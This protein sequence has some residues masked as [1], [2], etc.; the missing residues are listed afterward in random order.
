MSN[1]N[2]L[3]V[4]ANRIGQFFESMPDRP[5]ALEGIANHIRKFW[6]PRMRAEFLRILDAAEGAEISPIVREAVQAH[7][8]LLGEA[9]SAAR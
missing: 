7:R 4:M 2:N 3:I 9:L 6:E 1:A 8:A 5:E